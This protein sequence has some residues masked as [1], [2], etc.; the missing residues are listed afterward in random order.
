MKYVVNII[1]NIEGGGKKKGLI[2]YEKQAIDMFN[3]YS[4]LK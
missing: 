1:V 4:L 2:D 3:I